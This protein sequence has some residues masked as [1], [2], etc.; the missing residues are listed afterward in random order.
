MGSQKIERLELRT[1]RDEL[2]FC[3]T[4]TPPI[5]DVMRC[6]EVKRFEHWPVAVTATA[7]PAKRS[8]SRD[9]TDGAPNAIALAT[10]QC[11]QKRCQAPNPR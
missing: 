5:C 11:R 7:T 9:A 6:L 4:A 1:E 2:A 10:I 8:N 3:R